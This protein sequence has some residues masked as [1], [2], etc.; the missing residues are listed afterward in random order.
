MIRYLITDPSYYT[1]HPTKFRTRL[2][3]AIRRHRPTHIA[4]RDK[5][6]PKLKKI[7]ARVADLDI[8]I[9]QDFKLARRIGKRRIHLTSSQL[10]MAKALR[11]AGFEVWLSAHTPQDLKIARSSRVAYVT[12]SPIFFSPGKGE[13]LGLRSL[14]RR[15]RTY[16]KII[17][18]GGVVH[19]SQ[20]HAIKRARAAGFASIRYFI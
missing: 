8:I 5:T 16:K 14:R 1:S 10:P 17:A 7:A 9:N 13:P 20:I 3:K 6:N 15:S 11:R 18:L 12:Y 2:L 19:R 4:L